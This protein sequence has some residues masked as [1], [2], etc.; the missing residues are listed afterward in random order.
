MAKPKNPDPKLIVEPTVVAPQLF[1]LPQINLPNI[2]DPFGV[3]SPLSSGPGTGGGMGSGQG[4]GVGEGRG[5]GV[6][7]VKAGGWAEERSVTVFSGSV[8]AVLL[9]R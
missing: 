8:A 1:Q 6:V 7:P 9:R 5:P 4:R 2:G 3:P